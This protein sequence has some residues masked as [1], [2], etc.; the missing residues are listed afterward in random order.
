L[1]RTEELVDADDKQSVQSFLKSLSCMWLVQ[2]HH[3]VFYNG[4]HNAMIF[5]VTKAVVS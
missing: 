4:L 5:V 3:A 2:L 1:D